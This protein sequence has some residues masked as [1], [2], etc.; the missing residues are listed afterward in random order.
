MGNV[1][2]TSAAVVL[3]SALFCISVSSQPARPRSSAA[4][5]PVS[6][7]AAGF[8]ALVAQ[9]TAAREANDLEK[10][11]PLYQKAVELNPK[12]T[13]GYWYLGT[14]NY[15]LDRFEASRDAFRRVTRLTPENAEAWAFEGLSDYQLKNYEDALSALLRAR[16]QGLNPKQELAGVVRWHAAV[17]LNRIE[18]Y[19]KALDVLREFA[20][21]GNDGP[22]VIEAFGIATLRMPLLPADV[23]GTKREMVMLAGR[24]NYFAAARLLSA[25]QKAFEE[26]V[27]RYPETPNV[28]YAYGVFLISEQPDKAI[29]QLKAELE[30]SP[31]HPWAKMHLAFEYIRRAEWETARPYAE[32]AVQEGPNLWISR[33]ALGQVLL[34]TGDVEGAVREYEAGVKLA[35]ESPSMRFALARAY[36]RAGRSSDAEREQKEFARLDR[37]MR[38]QRLGAQSVG[39]IELDAPAGDTSSPPQ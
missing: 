8:D 38:T 14:L 12:W 39:G 9:A 5:R 32:Q 13:E 34:E 23:P 3:L 2:R 30:I 28:H 24:A 17:L 7:P 26:L 29:E 31:R 6:K 16:G 19:E 11:I 1:F 35:P 33:R 18:D 36:R 10:A 15:E 22:R 37:L 21:E 20:R 27:A 25:S 4:A